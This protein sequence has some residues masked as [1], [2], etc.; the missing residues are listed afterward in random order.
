MIQTLL[1]NRN[2]SEK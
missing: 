2:Q 1:D